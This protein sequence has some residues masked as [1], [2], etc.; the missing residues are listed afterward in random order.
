MNKLLIKQ[1]CPDCQGTRLRHESRA[2]TIQGKNIIDIS[3]LPLTELANWLTELPQTIQPEDE[4]IVAPILADLCERLCRLLD[5]G[6]GYLTL[7]RASPSLSAGEAQRLRLAALLGSGLTGVLYVLDEPTTGLHQRDTARLLAVLQ[8]IRDLGNT[9]LV[10]EH[11][12]ELFRQADYIIDI[13]PGGG[14]NGGEVV[15]VGTPQQIAANPKSMSGAYLSGRLTNAPLH[16]RR[17][18]NG[19]YLTIQG[20]REHNLKNVDVQLPLNSFIAITGVSG[21]GKSS[22]LFD[23]LDKAGRQHFNQ[24]TDPIGAHDAIT[25]WHYLDKI[26]TIDQSAIGRSPR[27]NAATYTDIFTAVRKTF[28]NTAAAQQNNLTARHFSFNV[29]GG[30]CERCQG[31]GQLTVGMH[32]LPDVMVRCPA[33]QG[34]RFNQNILAIDYKGYSIADVLD[35]TIEEAHQLFADVPAVASRLALMHDVGLGYL[36]LGQPAN[37]LS[38]GEAQ[39]IKLAKELGRRATGKTLYLLDEPTTGLHPADVAHLLNVLQGLVTQGHTVVVVEHN[40]DVIN[41]VDWV[42]DLGPEGGVAGGEIIATGTP[43][44]IAKSQNSFTGHYL[45][46]SKCDPAKN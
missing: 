5:V 28:A 34:S 29:V 13:G 18:R 7:D 25:G 14:R 37:T 26:I 16:P 10:I 46:K 8:K 24:A 39:R 23:I 6:I 44:E 19:K 40:I 41:A 30:R 2:V 45:K 38:G 42:I 27:S 33:C 43:E 9:V 1:A 4:A 11:D 36:K 3:Q 12:V 21:S 35:L 31:A 15:A 22:L 17:K 32:F 20:A